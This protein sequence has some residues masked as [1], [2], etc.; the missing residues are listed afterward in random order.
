LFF[1][2]YTRSELWLDEA[3][4]VSISQL[5][6]S[7]LYEALRHDGAPPLYYLL[8]KGWTSIFGTGNVAARSLSGLFMTAAVVA[9]YFAARRVGG[10]QVAFYAAIVMVVNPFAIRYA[11]EARM[12][13]L[14]ILLIS[15]GIIVFDRVVERPTIGRAV[16][17]G[18]IIV[19]GL[20]TQYWNFYLLPVLVALLGWMLWRGD[21]RNAARHLLIAMIFGILAFLPWMPTFIYQ[22]EHTGTPWGTPVLPALPFG[23]TLRDFAGGATFGTEVQEGWVLFVIMFALWLLGTFA[24]GIDDRRIE[25]NLVPQ[26]DV[27]AIAFVGWVGLAVALSLN[28]IAGGAF[29]TRYSSLV[30]PFFV[31]LAAR[32]ITTVLDTRV[33]V[34]V[35]VVIVALGFVA[36]IRNLMTQR[37]QAGEV[38]AVLRKDAH[39]ADVVVYCP[40][41]VGPAV[42]R[43]APKGLEEFVFPSG[44]APDRVDWV[45]Y[46][47]RLERVDVRA[48][49]QDA[50]RRAEGRTLWLVRAPGYLTHK[51]LCETLS[52]EFERARQRVPRTQPKNEVFEKP[53]I[54]EFGPGAEVASVSPSAEPPEK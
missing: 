21:D 37:T 31:I 35:A 12:Y 9:T 49:A 22:G 8:L 2:F 17:F 44:A 39:E 26:M 45:D 3:L 10:R 5:P 29:Q 41:Q 46:K 34:G 48:F 25:L 40:D 20:Y 24:V 38:A 4:S 11:T 53:L 50:L 13:A 27:R 43:L 52:G 47:K 16:P 30:F 36:G 14:E 19:I 51:A 28:Y 23:Y 18:F 33:R 15:C 7:D 6:F 32:G 1:F 54:E 42:H